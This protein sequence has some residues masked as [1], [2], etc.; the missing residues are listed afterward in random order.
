MFGPR[1][2]VSCLSRQLLHQL[3]AEMFPLVSLEHCS[4]LVK[5]V[6]ATARDVKQQLTKRFRSSSPVSIVKVVLAV[7][8]V[9]VK[10]E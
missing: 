9:E 7:S 1:V 4:L 5:R 8:V 3:T 10:P 2:F 6:G